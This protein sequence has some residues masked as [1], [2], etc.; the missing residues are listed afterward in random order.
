MIPGGQKSRRNTPLRLPF[1]G[2]G[3]AL[4]FAAGLFA[5]DAVPHAWA[6]ATAAR[7]AM[8]P[9]IVNVMSMTEDEIGPLRPG[10]DLRSRTLVDSEHGTIAI[11]S[12]NVMK[13][14]HADADEIQLIL[15][16]TGSFWLGDREVQV[17]PGDLV[18][19]PRRT[20]HAGSRA[21]TGR[22]RAVAI[23]LPPQR[24]D[25]VHPVP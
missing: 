25:D 6:Q 1:I 19:I 11:Q 3:F 22:F 17:K 7:P 4:A 9:Q 8:A 14:F 24:A 20:A 15:D 10:A 13:H 23:K 5:G 18:I 12:G 16:G 21:S 2:G